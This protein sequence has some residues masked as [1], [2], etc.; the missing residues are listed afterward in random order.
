MIRFFVSSMFLICPRYVAIL[1]SVIRI[2]NEFVGLSIIRDR[3]THP[4]NTTIHITI[5]SAIMSDLND[6]FIFYSPLLV[7][8]T[9][10]SVRPLL[11]RTPQTSTICKCISPA[12][13]LE[14]ASNTPRHIR[15]LSPRILTLRCRSLLTL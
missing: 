5:I 13:Q 15:L 12:P 3:V 11:R 9:K 7:L 8:S 14:S 2:V 1:P 10:Y 4:V 6:F